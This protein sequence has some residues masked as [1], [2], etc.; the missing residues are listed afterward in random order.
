MV[1]LLRDANALLA[2]A[3]SNDRSSTRRID[4]DEHLIGIDLDL[5]PSVATDDDD[6]NESNALCCIDGATIRSNVTLRYDP[7]DS[8]EK[9]RLINGFVVPEAHDSLRELLEFADAA[10]ESESSEPAAAAANRVGIVLEFETRTRVGLYSLY[11][12]GG[13]VIGAELLCGVDVQHDVTA[14]A[15]DGAAASEDN[16]VLLLGVALL[17]QRALAALSRFVL[18]R[19]MS[20]FGVLQVE[21]FVRERTPRWVKALIMIYL[22]LLY[23]VMFQLPR[24]TLR[25]SLR[26]LTL[27]EPVQA[28][29]WSLLLYAL[30]IPI[31]LAVQVAAFN[32][33]PFWE[34]WAK[35]FIVG[36]ITLFGQLK[37]RLNGKCSA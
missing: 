29:L 16:W 24:A 21:Q 25:L 34:T 3:T 13:H 18:T 32:L 26:L 14:G 6:D 31:K 35:Q 22:S 17:A 7:A 4:K 10:C 8:C 11:D 20:L 5:R 12:G 2:A 23:G 36:N 28:C 15:D 27:L 33:Q 9:Q 19:I 37:N 30:V 1:T